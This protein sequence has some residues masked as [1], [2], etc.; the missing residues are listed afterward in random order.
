MSDLKEILSPYID[1][2]KSP[3]FGTFIVIWT[4][5]NWEFFLKLYNI[6]FYSNYEYQIEFVQKAINGQNACRLF[7]KPMG[8]TIVSL[9]TFYFTNGIGLAIKEFYSMRMKSAILDLVGKGAKT[10]PID[11]HERIKKEGKL[12]DI[13]YQELEKSKSSIVT[14]LKAFEKNNNT[15]TEEN[16]ALHEKITA[17]TTSTQS[18]EEDKKK[19]TENDTFL[20]NIIEAKEEEKKTMTD[21][22]VIKSEEIKSLTQNTEVLRAEIQKHNQFKILVATYGVN[23]SINFVTDFIQRSLQPD[24]VFQVGNKYMGPDPAPSSPKSLQVTYSVDGEP[25]HVV[26]QEHNFVKRTGNIIYEISNLEIVKHLQ[27]LINVPLSEKMA[28][29]W[30]HLTNFLVYDFMFNDKNIAVDTIIEGNS[31]EIQVFSR[32]ENANNFLNTTVHSTLV[33][34]GIKVEITSNKRL[35]VGRFDAQDSLILVSDRLNQVLTIIDE[36]PT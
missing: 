1:R 22:I 23:Q 2:I 15:L 4:F 8:W 11:E 7:W 18:L 29:E 5:Y 32:K 25:Q 21:D 12:L 28:K 35:L 6:P 20:K 3:F 33:S 26:I 30:Y 16:K 14:D 17:L 34:K 19:A 10:V 27:T 36:I 24:S 9:I 31:W 13:R